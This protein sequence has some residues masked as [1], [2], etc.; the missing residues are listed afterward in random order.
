MSYFYPSGGYSPTNT[1]PSP[2]F[3]V[4]A[5]PPFGSFE[6][7]VGLLFNPASLYFWVLGGVIILILLLRYTKV[8]AK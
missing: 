6:S 1:M 4:D 7:V 3:G 8:V 5:P 2:T